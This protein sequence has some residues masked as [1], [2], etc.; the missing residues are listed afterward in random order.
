MLLV[1]GQ[2][3]RVT[4][5]KAGRSD[6]EQWDEFT[7]VVRDWGQTLYVVAGRE[8]VESSAMPSEGDQV[9]LEV[10]VRSYVN[11]EGKPGH[12]YT[13]HRRNAEAESRLYAPGVKAAS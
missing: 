7:L 9:A 2:I 5:R 6:G 1:T 4:S 13:G 12:G 8:L 11:R 3:E 10:S